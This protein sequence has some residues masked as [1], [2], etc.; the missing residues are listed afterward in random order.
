MAKWYHNL[1]DRSANTN[2][3]LDSSQLILWVTLN[4][5]QVASWAAGNRLAASFC[6][7][8]DNHLVGVGLRN[9][10]IYFTEVPFKHL[11]FIYY[12]RLQNLTLTQSSNREHGRK[13]WMLKTFNRGGLFLWAFLVALKPA[14][15]PKEKRLSIKKSLLNAGCY[16]H[17]S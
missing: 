16:P 6:P 9:S 13:G 2:N 12:K 5:R 1:W 3:F 4:A 8:N 17:H 11:T 7:T 10:V 15:N 14:Q